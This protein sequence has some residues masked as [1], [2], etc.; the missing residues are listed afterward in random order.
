MLD[1]ILRLKLALVKTLDEL[2]D[3]PEVEITRQEW[4]LIEKVVSVLQPFIDATL[5]LSKQD[6]SIS[7]VIPF[8]T[9][10]IEG[11][12]IDRCHWYEPSHE[13]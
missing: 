6:A 8:V 5:E 4:I 10:I 7:T 13:G 12:D 9:S 1:S 11:L 2:D 3:P